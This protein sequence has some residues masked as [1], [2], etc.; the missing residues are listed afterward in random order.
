MKMRNFCLLL[1]SAVLFS[2]TLGPDYKR[3]ETFSDAQIKKSLNLKDESLSS[4]HNWYKDFNDEVLNTLVEKAV[5]NN[6]D[7]QIAIS[8]L[9]QSRNALK[10]NSTNYLPQLDASGKYEFS[11][12]GKNAGVPLEYN[13][14]QTDFDVSW[15]LDIWGAGR[16]Q[17]EEYKALSDTAAAN[18]ENVKISV[19]AEVV[20]DYYNLRTAEEQLRIAKENLNLQQKIFDIVEQKYQNGLADELSYKQAG[21]IVEQTKASI[22]DF[23][24]QITTYKNALSVLV[25]SLPDENI[26]NLQGE[27]PVAKRFMFDLNKLYQFPVSTLR[28]RPDIMAA[29]YNLIAKNA[30]IGQAVAELY[31]SV[32]I[33]ALAG[34][35]SF[36]GHKLFSSDSSAY[37]YTPALQLPIFHWN[38]LRNNIKLQKNIY[39]EYLYIYEQ[40]VINAASEISNSVSKLKNEYARNNSLRLSFLRIKDVLNLTME[41]YDNGLIEF[42]DVLAQEHNLLKAHQDLIGSNGALYTNIAAFYKAI[43]Q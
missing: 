18:L 4:S 37:G 6:K 15:E 27:N 13:Y 34:Y 21:Y 2:C 31:P 32:N 26:A 40:A 30:A 38:A 28:L 19:V 8:R 22:P 9:K 12:V 36:S 24:S 7:V 23:Q 39:K 17:T 16:R 1:F 25:S 33:S 20:S 14:F 3:P 10:I 5:E 35:Q 11:K 43:G 29:E 42:S 41:K